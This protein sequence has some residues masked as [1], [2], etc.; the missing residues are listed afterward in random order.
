MLCHNSRLSIVGH[1]RVQN[2]SERDDAS[3]STSTDSNSGKVAVI[4][5]PPAPGDFPDFFTQT[6]KE[7]ATQLCRGLSPAEIAE[8]RGVTVSTIHNQSWQMCE[9]MGVES[10]E[11]LVK[12]LFERADSA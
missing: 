9:K 2:L 3:E 5:V 6:E 1:N 12:I 4:A 7:V 10:R 11:E 8:L